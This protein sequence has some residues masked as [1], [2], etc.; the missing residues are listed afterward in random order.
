[1]GRKPLDVHIRFE[2]QEEKILQLTKELEEAKDE[3]QKLLEEQEEADKKKL[4]EAFRKSKRSLD[5]ILEY[6]KGKADI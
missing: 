1:M 4:I 3:Y 6:M 2:R 5:E